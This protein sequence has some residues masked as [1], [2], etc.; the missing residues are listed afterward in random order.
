LHQ[1]VGAQLDL[2]RFDIAVLALIHGHIVSG[3]QRY[4]S[5]NLGQS[6]PSLFAPPYD[7]DEHSVTSCRR[8]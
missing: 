2:A 5:A 6:T 1:V 8:D 3:A 4:E 7:R